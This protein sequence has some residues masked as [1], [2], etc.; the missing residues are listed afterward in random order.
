MALNRSSVHLR[1]EMILKRWNL[2]LVRNV[3]PEINIAIGEFFR[4]HVSILLRYTER[5][6]HSHPLD[7]SSLAIIMEFK[8]SSSIFYEYRNSC[9]YVIPP[10]NGRKKCQ[11]IC[12][13][14]ALSDVSLSFATDPHFSNKNEMMII[15]KKQL[16]GVGI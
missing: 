6:E 7:F 14:L 1:S 3:C 8:E 9:C 5:Q 10:V 12:R 16:F 2:L 11:Q 4:R 13:L 15:I